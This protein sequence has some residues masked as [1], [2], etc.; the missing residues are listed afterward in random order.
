MDGT[1]RGWI[2]LSH[3]TLIPELCPP[4]HAM[5]LFRFNRSYLL[6]VGLLSALSVL[7]LSSAQASPYLSEIVLPVTGAT[8][9]EI[10]GLDAAGATLLVVNAS[11]Q[12]LSVQQV[13]PIT[14]ATTGNA[15]LVV[16]GGVGWDVLAPPQARQ[17]ATVQLDVPLF[18]DDIPTA[19]VLIYGQSVISDNASLGNAAA[20]SGISLDTPIVDWVSFARGTNDEAAAL[21]HGPSDEGLVALGIADLP[22][23]TA[24]TT[25]VSVLARALTSE[26]PARGSLLAGTPNGIAADP[27]GLRDFAF[28][29]GLQN[30]ETLPRADEEPPPIPEPS[31]GLILGL[32][33]LA[34]TRR[35]AH[36]G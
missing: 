26:G 21:L 4:P 34:A 2:P 3:P 35:S 12:R 5:R 30:P 14:P 1:D 8:A 29:P 32:G 15:G 25:G 31:L 22:R 6:A 27:L 10:D 20:V 18:F 19:L 23:P 33:L 9:V 11:R 13:I 36:R 17:A 7:P 24:G 28:S 16:V